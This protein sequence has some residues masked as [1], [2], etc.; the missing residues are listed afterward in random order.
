MSEKIAATTTILTYNS[1]KTLAQCL[2]SVQ[3]FDDILVCDGGSTDETLLIAK[4]YGARVISQGD[5]PGPILN[6]TEV[7]QKTF[8]EAKYDWIFII[9]SDEYADR[10][11]I[12]SIVE[13]L[14]TNEPHVAYQIERVPLINGKEIYHMFS[15]PDLIVRFVNRKLVQWRSKKRV[16]EHFL[17]PQEIALK[18]LAGILLSPWPTIEEGK[19]K[20]SYYLSLSLGKI[21]KYRPKL[22]ITVRAILKN[23]FIAG[24]IF[25]VGLWLLLRY[26]ARNGALPWGYNMRFVRYHTIIA[27]ER[28]KQY[29]HGTAYVFHTN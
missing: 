24:K 26:G 1:A 5:A 17:F 18:K 11:C 21:V 3:D 8:R 6:F 28:L 27:I 29:Y 12:N 13:C 14:K 2:E 16:H 15:S 9:D 22:K 10:E 4:K 19:K 7:R 23:L 25:F 20:D